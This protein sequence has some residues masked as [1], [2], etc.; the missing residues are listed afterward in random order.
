MGTLLQVPEQISAHLPQSAG[1][2]PAQLTP[3]SLPPAAELAPVQAAQV[4]GAAGPWVGE[5]DHLG[6]KVEVQVGSETR[7]KFYLHSF[8]FMQTRKSD[9]DGRGS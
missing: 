5:E 6:E 8:T 2:M 3:V 7:Q 1:Q 4:G 9:K